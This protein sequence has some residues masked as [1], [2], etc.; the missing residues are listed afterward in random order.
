VIHWYVP[1]EVGE[2]DRLKG[3]D[4]DAARAETRAFLFGEG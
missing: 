2:I 4:F 3:A 1:E